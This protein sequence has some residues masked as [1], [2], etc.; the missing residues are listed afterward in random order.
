MLVVSA[1]GSDELQALADGRGETVAAWF[2]GDSGERERAHPQV[3][4]VLRMSRE[5]GVLHGAS[6]LATAQAAGCDAD[7]TLA[8]V[9]DG[10]GRATPAA[11]AARSP[12]WE[13]TAAARKLLS[14]LARIPQLEVML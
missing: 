11:D 2:G 10:G 5:D 6:S 7:A 4:E 13:D 9:I 1:E 8:P 12:W 3:K 14:V